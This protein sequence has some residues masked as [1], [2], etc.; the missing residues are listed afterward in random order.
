MR[1][2]FLFPGQG[3]QSPNFL[4]VLP[5]HAA[6]R[7][8]FDEATR[9]LGSDPRHLDSETALQST[10]AV[11]IAILVA[12]VAYTELLAAEGARP[13]AVA[14]LSSGAF[15]AAVASGS[16]AFADALRLIRLRSEAMAHAFGEGYGM[17]AILGLREAAVRTLV[18]RVA[19]S[20]MPLYVSSINAPDEII[21]AG[22]DGALSAAHEAAE[23]AGARARR[24]WV[25]VPSHGSLLDGVSAQLREAIH[26]V[27]LKQPDIPYISN[28]RARAVH[29]QKDIAEDLIVNVSRTVHWYESTRLLYELGC[30][31]FI[32]VP[33]GRAL[34]NLLKR[35]FPD[36]RA[37][38]A[39]DVDLQ[40][41]LHV[42]R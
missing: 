37:L 2:A 13:D 9:V 18:E 38:P 8:V 21:L 4:H 23:R 40:S 39:T 31:V 26:E 35:E 19:S 27:Q 42:M 5:D 15:A 16:L 12:G 29:S 10:V 30:R 28:H 33:P 14:G 20:A 24:L 41:I 36:V 6:V 7:G 3:S 11:Q 34:T 32:E 25:S 22:S 1:V 17:L